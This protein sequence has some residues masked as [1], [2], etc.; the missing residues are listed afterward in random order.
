[1]ALNLDELHLRY[2][3]LINH[4]EFSRGSK[5]VHHLIPLYLLIILIIKL[6]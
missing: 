3:C 4:E 5:Y 1:M 2:V 6:T